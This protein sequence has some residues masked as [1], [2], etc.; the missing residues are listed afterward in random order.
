M[1]GS[2]TI[3]LMFP[4]RG[5]GIPLDHGYSLFSAIS[6]CLETRDH[7]WLHEGDGVGLHFIRGTYVGPGRLTLDARARFGVRISASRV[8]AFL[9]LAGKQLQLHGN[10]IRVGIP[11]PR[12]LTPAT[13]LYAHL[14]TTRNGQD[15]RRFDAEIARQLD[16]LSVGGSVVRGE[17]RVITVRD[18]KIVCHGLT[19]R[20]LSEYA[21]IRLQEAG[22]GGRRKM[23]CGVFL[24]N[25]E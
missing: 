18:R 19:V 13:D 1:G 6:R 22:V 5:R 11:R 23:G 21:S 7:H 24:P 2:P 15:E 8:A 12:A 17:R 25:E 3:D 14:V 20:G 9:P 16:E 4:V 10:A